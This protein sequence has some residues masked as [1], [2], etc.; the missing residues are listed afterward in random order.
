MGS[1]QILSDI[2]CFS[3]GTLFNSIHNK[4]PDTVQIETTNA[5]NSRCIICPHKKMG[6]S[7]KTMDNNIFKKVID[8]C[9]KFNC[10]NVH[11]HNFGEP[12][13]DTNIVQRIK[14]AKD[15]GLPRIKIFSN[16]SLLSQEMSE[17]LIK[18]GLDEI[19]ISFDGANKEEYEKIRYPLK[20]D[21]VVNNIR[22]LIFI[23]NKMRSSLKIEI[24]CNS[25]SDNSSTMKSL[26][27]C[28]D[29]FSFGKLHNWGDSEI[30]CSARS[31]IRKPCARVWRTFTILSDGSAS[32]CCL[33]FD[34]KVILGDLHESSISEIWRNSQYIS[35]RKQHTNALHKNIAICSSCS[36]SYI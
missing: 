17:N 6:R 28:V 21:L 24:A 5:C 35:M 34:G 26:E 8:E 30:A 19:K 29:N 14:Y 3:I 33:D 27:N 25:T 20:F 9:A 11:L 32:L 23:R 2:V 36:K 12:L 31:K 18:A 1:T 16:G 4:F 22:D 7:I 15:K 13:L 10:G